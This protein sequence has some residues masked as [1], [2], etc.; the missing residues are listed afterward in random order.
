MT[1]VNTPL[2][3]DTVQFLSN[4]LADLKKDANYA[5]PGEFYD[6]SKGHNALC[7]VKAKIE[8]ISA[9]LAALN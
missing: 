2:T 3:L 6:S 9:F 1:P 7:M 5:Y 8:V 4:T